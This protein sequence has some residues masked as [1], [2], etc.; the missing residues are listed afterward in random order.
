MVI[1]DGIYD[2]TGWWLTYPF[3]K[4]WSSSVGMMTFPYMKWKIKAIFETTNQWRM[5]KN[6]RNCRNW[7]ILA[8]RWFCSKYP[9]HAFHLFRV[10]VK[11]LFTAGTVPWPSAT[12]LNTGQSQPTKNL[13]CQYN[14]RH[15]TEETQ[16]LSSYPFGNLEVKNIPG[17]CL[18]AILL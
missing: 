18:Q 11:L 14:Q 2:H 8:I 3:E 5:P 7:R 4:W 16:C 6:C 13:S 10:L 15:P 1:N 9:P 12:Y 17:S